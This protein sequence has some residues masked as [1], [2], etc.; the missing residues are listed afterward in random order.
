MKDLKSLPLILYC[1]YLIFPLP[2]PLLTEIDNFLQIE[3][4]RKELYDHFVAVVGEVQQRSELRNIVLEKRLNQVSEHLEKKDAVLSEVL[5]AA[6]LDPSSFSHVNHQLETIVDE[7]NQLV[8]EL[9]EEVATLRRMYTDLMDK[10]Q[11][12]VKSTLKPKNTTN[13]PNISV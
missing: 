10:Y 1:T 6:N 9:R 11:S 12:T 4:E 3:Q 8:G 2:I 13:F 5:S 7:K